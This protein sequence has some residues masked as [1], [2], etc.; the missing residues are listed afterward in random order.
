MHGHMNVKR[1]TGDVTTP[2]QNSRCV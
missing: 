2:V 1:V